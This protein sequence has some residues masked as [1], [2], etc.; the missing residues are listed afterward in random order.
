M[1]KSVHS[2]KGLAIHATDGEIGKVDELYFDDERWTV[3]YLVVDTG[4]WLD[5]RLVL[6]SPLSVSQADWESG[7]LDVLL[8]KQQV[9]NS[10]DIDTQKPVSRQHE[11]EYLNYYGY[12]TY[13]S[14]PGLLGAGFSPPMLIPPPI[15]APP[16]APANE[17]V[18]SHLRSSRA[19]TGYEIQATD[20]DFGHVADF[21]LDL[22]TWAIVYVEVSTRNWLPG[23]KVLI[24]PQW[25]RAVTWPDLTLTVSLARETIQGAPEYIESKPITREYEA[26]LH[27]YYGV[28][29]YW[30][31]SGNSK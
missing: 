25:I 11:S 26:A 8:T 5:Q 9:E 2:L 28:P 12:P 18:D 23:K 13:W 6:I 20:G 31:G 15:P 14:D 29:H 27:D 10:P 7:R 16:S 1:L 22:A 30:S 17:V 4:G 3:R 21:I 24:S 19:V